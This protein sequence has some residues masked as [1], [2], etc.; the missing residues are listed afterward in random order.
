MNIS[1]HMDS[2]LAGVDAVGNDIAWFGS[3]AAPTIRVREMTISGS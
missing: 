3:S 2:M 1:G